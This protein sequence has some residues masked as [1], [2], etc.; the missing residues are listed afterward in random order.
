MF[1]SHFTYML[2]NNAEVSPFCIFLIYMLCGIYF[3]R[4]PVSLLCHDK[5]VKPNDRLF[6]LLFYFD[7]LIQNL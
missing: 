5:D 4:L 7:G 2:S 6:F 1:P 3:Y